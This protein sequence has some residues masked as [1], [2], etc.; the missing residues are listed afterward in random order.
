MYVLIYTVVLLI[1]VYHS[2]IRLRPL[3]A[4]V[5]KRG[6]SHWLFVPVHSTLLLLLLTTSRCRS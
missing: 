4:A 6:I 5:G 2:G 1:L 3:A